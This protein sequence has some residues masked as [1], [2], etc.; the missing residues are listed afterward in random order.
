MDDAGPFPP[1]VRTGETSFPVSVEWSMEQLLSLSKRDVL[2]MW[3]AAPAATLDE[4]QGHFTGLIPNAGDS[5]A[6]A[7]ALAYMYDTEQRFG[8]WL[9]KAF[10]KTGDN[11]GEGYN[12]YR[13]PGEKL[14]GS[15]RLLQR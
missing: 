2:G 11:T 8:H 4:L 7:R 1:P 12:R 10:R 9:G 5:A 3:R 14:N 15:S 13:T 6:Q